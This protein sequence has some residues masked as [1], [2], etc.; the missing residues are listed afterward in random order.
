MG[1]KIQRKVEGRDSEHG[2]DRNPTKNAKMRIHAGRPVEWDNL[3]WNSLGLF[4]C[5]GEGLDGT[6]DF[7][8][9]IRNGLSRFASHDPGKF[10]PSIVE[11]SSNAL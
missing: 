6:R 4:R 2:T 1:D 11:R 3:A 7:P 10:F 5:D 9:C 8:T